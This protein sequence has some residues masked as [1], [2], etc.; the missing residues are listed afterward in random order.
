[1]IRP[2]GPEPF[3]QVIPLPETKSAAPVIECLPVAAR[4]RGSCH[5]CRGAIRVDEPIQRVDRHWTHEE[6]VPFD[7]VPGWPDQREV[8]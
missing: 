1:M 5:E 6:C 3:G 7:A 8:A 2:A 4:H